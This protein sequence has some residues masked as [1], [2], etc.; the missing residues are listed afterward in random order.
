MRVKGLRH[1][2]STE[3]FELELQRILNRLHN[4]PS[5]V[6]WVLFNEGWGQFATHRLTD[7]V[8]SLDPSRPVNAT[9][10]WLDVGAGDLVDRHDYRLK[11]DAPQGDGVR[12]L[13]IGEYGGLGWP[14]EAHLWNPQ[15]RN[16]GYHAYHSAEALQEAYRV[17]T[18]RL[19]ELQRSEGI[20]A[21]IYTQTTDVEGEVNGLMTYD[22]AIQKLPPEWLAEVHAPFWQIAPRSVELNKSS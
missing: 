11:P 1:S 21:A 19:L 10:G 8:R 18:A 22:R 12:A 3:Q 16:W 15:M 7:R 4:H 17:L 13:V 20:C 5:I 14:I 6:L 9:S 2:R